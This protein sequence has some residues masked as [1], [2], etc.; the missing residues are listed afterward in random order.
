[1]DGKCRKIAL[2]G[3][4]CET[5]IGYADT[6][7]QC[8]DCCGALRMAGANVEYTGIVIHDAHS[9]R[10][11]A[12]AL[13]KSGADLL[14][15]CIGTWSEDNHLLELLRAEPLPLII[16]AS[17]AFD[18]GALCGAHQIASVLHDVGYPAASIVYGEAGNAQTAAE[19][20]EAA[21]KAEPATDRLSER[22]LRVGIIGSRVQG[23]TEIAFD[24]FAL[25]SKCGVLVIPIGETELL[26]GVAAAKPEDIDEVCK[27]VRG[28]GC[29]VSVQERPLRE[30]AAY[31]L[32]LRGIAERYALDGLSV[33]CYTRFMG[34]VCL[35]YSLLAEEGVGC[36]CEGDVNGAVMMCL[37][38][39]F[40]G[41]CINNTDLLYPDP[42]ANTI[43]FSHCG[44]S[45]FS[46]AD[47]RGI[48]LAPV[49]LMETGVCALFLPKTG[50]VTL[51]GLVGHGEKLRMSVMTGEAIETGMEFPGNPVKVKFDTP[52]LD[53]CREIAEKGCGHHWMAAY[54]DVSA[55]LEEYCRSHGVIYRRLGR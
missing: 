50:V 37:L 3:L 22:T 21:A 25:Y 34:K 13:K 18:T 23:M 44:S 45:G 39:R 36:A 46:L 35:G 52:V 47:A 4:A 30:A 8:S 6:P 20:L 51:A 1:M 2:I 41:G 28:W 49:R 54:G 11:A 26:D 7:R 38:G 43:L 14:L 24:E 5:E 9:T 27:R 33:K 40:S 32:A 48:T 29:R 55:Q 17:P 12:A 16:Q 42:E 53:I 31:Y 10:Q 15:I 19:I